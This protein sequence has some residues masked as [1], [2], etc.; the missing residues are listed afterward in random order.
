ME[1]FLPGTLQKSRLRQERGKEEGDFDEEDDEDAAW[2]EEF[3]LR[4]E[5]RKKEKEKRDRV[6]IETDLRAQEEA[7]KELYGEEHWEDVYAMEADMQRKFDQFV[8][9]ERPQLWPCLPLNMKFD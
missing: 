4:E 1:F 2:A 6:E 8:Q 3:L 7:M 9:D 5:K